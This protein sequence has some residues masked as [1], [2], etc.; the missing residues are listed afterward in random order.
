MGIRVL[1]V[2][3]FEV[4]CPFGRRLDHFA[5]ET[6]EGWYSL[7]RSLALPA[8]L[9]DLTR[10]VVPRG[11]FSQNTCIELILWWHEAVAA[12]RALPKCA[13]VMVT[14]VMRGTGDGFVAEMSARH[15][16]F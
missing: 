16:P 8:V 11:C 6:E 4:G 12:S 10:A 9:T 15:R 5:R 3:D 14:Q 13:A 2:H 7:E 1:P